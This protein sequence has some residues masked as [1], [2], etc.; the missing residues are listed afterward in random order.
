MGVEYRDRREWLKKV[1]VLGELRELRGLH[2]DKEMGAFI[3][4]CGDRSSGGCVV[5][6]ERNS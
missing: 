5:W 4:M 3:Q 6:S 2:W 1:E